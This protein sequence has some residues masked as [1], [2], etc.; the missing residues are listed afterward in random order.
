[1]ISDELK[2]DAKETVEDLRKMGVK[3]I[4]ML[5]GDSENVAKKVG[6]ILNLDKAICRAFYP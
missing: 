6:S 2:E 5:T 4:S 1:M 3:K